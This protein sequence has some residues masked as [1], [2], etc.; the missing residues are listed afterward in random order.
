MANSI[1]YFGRNHWLSDI[2]QRVSLLAR[3]RMFEKCP[4]GQTK[5]KRLRILDIGSTPDQERGD[6][7]CFIRWCMERGDEVSAA[8]VEDISVLKESYPELN[9]LDKLHPAPSKWI[10][11][12]VEY[13]W[14]IASA[15][16]EHVGS[17]NNQVH[18]LSECARIS[19]RLFITTPNRYHWLEFHTKLPFI[20]WLPRKIHRWI[21]ECLGMP[22]W[23]QEDNLNL[24][25]IHELESI[26]TKSLGSDFVFSVTSVWTLG[27]PSNL[28][29]IAHRRSQS[30]SV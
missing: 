18:F 14:C 22:F 12:D 26:A 15:V 25:S 3:R 2:Q 28:L 24:L 17:Y 29:L 19:Q 23:A 8:S 7:N 30:W 6:S 27:M 5:K 13:D 20:H 21:L 9:V 1:D 16:L 4:W 11:K 10:M